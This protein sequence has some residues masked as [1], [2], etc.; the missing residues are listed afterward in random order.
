MSY[1][2]S[3]PSDN[4]DIPGASGFS[5]QS[6][7]GLPE[8][9]QMCCLSHRSGQIT[10]RSGESYGFV[11][12]QQGRVIHALCG[13]FEGEEAIYLMLTWPGGGFSLDEDILPHK[14][15]VTLTW[16][17]LLFEG[18]RRADFGAGTPRLP[19][20]APVTTMEPVV[21]SR[22]KDSQ[23]KLTINLPDQAPTIYEL[24]TEYTHVGRTPGNE[25][26][27]P[28]PSVSSRHCIFVISGPDIVLRD[29]NS[30]NGTYVNGQAITEEILRPG[31]MIQL[32]VVQIKFEPG[33]KRPKLNMNASSQHLT[34]VQLEPERASFSFSTAK[35]PLRPKADPTPSRVLDDSHYVKGKSAISYDTLAKPPVKKQR[36]PWVLIIGGVVSILAVIAGGYYYFF[37]RQ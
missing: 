18:A 22:N 15:T 16:E 9:L 4:S 28:F 24:E 32:G 2:N 14:K 35:L 11:Y 33:I 17:Q 13:V 12:I 30:S 23:P 20:A 31:D 27:L 37:L 5:A 21:S 29:L 34:P 36:S 1:Q 10:F 26:V 19:S 25:I 7:M 8:V 6:Q 3:Q